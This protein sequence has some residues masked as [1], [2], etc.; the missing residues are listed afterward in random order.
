MKIAQ[1]YHKFLYQTL[2]DC[3]N[4]F[5]RK[6]VELYLRSYLE[7]CISI[8]FFRVPKFQ[9]IFIECI[10][11]KISQPIPEWK[12]V[13]WDLEDEFS[14]SVNQGL[15]KLFDWQVNFFELLP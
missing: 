12:G 8:S 13:N 15:I 4:K 1:Y 11:D 9:T 10:S 6:D 3:L 2:D 5:C 14:Q 7:I